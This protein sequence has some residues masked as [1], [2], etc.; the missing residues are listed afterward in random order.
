MRAVPGC[1]EGF[2]VVSWDP[3]GT[4]AS[5][6]VRCFTSTASEDRFWRGVQIPVTAA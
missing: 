5:D 1:A 2:N 3:Q 6:P 4:N